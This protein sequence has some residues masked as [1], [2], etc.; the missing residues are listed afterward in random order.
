[1]ENLAEH[2]LL[3]IFSF[4]V[5]LECLSYARVSSSWKTIA[6]RH[7]Y[8]II[9]K[10]TRSHQNLTFELMGSDSLFTVPLWMEHHQAMRT[11]GHL[12]DP[13]VLLDKMKVVQV[14]ERIIEVNKNQVILVSRIEDI[15]QTQINFVTSIDLSGSR[16]NDKSIA[17]TLV[18]VNMSGLLFLKRLSVRG[19]S[20]LK[21]L[22]LPTQLIALDA[23]SCSQL[24]SIQLRSS[25]ESNNGS[26]SLRILNLNGCRQLKVS[27]SPDDLFCL[28]NQSLLKVV[29][30]DMTSVNS[31]SESD[32]ACC[33]SQ[34]ES[35]KSVSFRYIA[36]DELVFALC[37][38][39]SPRN[40]LQM[41]DMAFSSL[42][43]DTSVDQLIQSASQLERLNLRGCPCI[44]SLCYNRTALHLL[45]KRNNRVQSNL[46]STKRGRKGDV[47][48]KTS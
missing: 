44:S 19:C 26:I 15:D 32:L 6:Y 28:K 43:S 37:S 21:H 29:E 4:A 3:H 31:I 22:I 20:N 12:P 8:M 38:S 18:Y 46:S 39:L 40:S 14:D 30:L 17:K 41:L 33:V 10:T 27:Q 1:M 7:S 11:K 13:L 9:L 48:F 36:N 42:L 5:P 16:I 34:S 24:L 2:I 25:T 35:L 23:H 47:L 45:S